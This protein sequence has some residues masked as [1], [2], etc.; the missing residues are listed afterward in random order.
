[1]LFSSPPFRRQDSSFVLSHLAMDQRHGAMVRPPID[2][3]IC[4]VLRTRKLI[5]KSGSRFVGQSCSITVFRPSNPPINVQ[6]RRT[7]RMDNY[8]SASLCPPL[9]P[10]WWRACRYTDYVSCRSGLCGVLAQPE[11]SRHHQGSIRA[12]AKA[13]PCVRVIFTGAICPHTARSNA[14]AVQNRDV[15]R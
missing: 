9:D 8:G 13:M 2:P 6:D 12:A 4:G 15:R 11:R 7:L 1:M 14:P 5:L 10:S 3:A